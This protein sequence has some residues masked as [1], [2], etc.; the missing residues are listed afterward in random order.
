MYVHIVAFTVPSYSTYVLG[1]TQLGFTL[2]Q[3]KGKGMV[4][5]KCIMRKDPG[6]KGFAFFYP[7]PKGMYC[8]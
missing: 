2:F 3:N 7:T 6:V 4:K 5:D 8:E 1:S